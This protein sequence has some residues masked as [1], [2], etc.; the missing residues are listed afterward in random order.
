LKIVAELGSLGHTLA[1]GVKGEAHLISGYHW[2][3]HAAAQ[4]LE[5]VKVERIC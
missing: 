4:V 1:P 5:R 3:G 2:A